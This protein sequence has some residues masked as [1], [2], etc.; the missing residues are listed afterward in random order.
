MLLRE[1][2]HRCLKAPRKLRWNPSPSSKVDDSLAQAED[3]NFV[4]LLEENEDG[5]WRCAV[6]NVSPVIHDHAGLDFLDWEA[7]GV[8]H[9]EEETG[10]EPERSYRTSQFIAKAVV[11]KQTISSMPLEWIYE[12]VQ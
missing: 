12:T 2:K 4:R 11:C 3:G 7:V 9:L 5:S 6:L 10:N 8:M 1:R